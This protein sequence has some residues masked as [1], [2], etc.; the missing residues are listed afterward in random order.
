MRTQMKKET[1]REV[2]LQT[3]RE[4]VMKRKMNCTGKT[5]CANIE[6]EFLLVVKDDLYNSI[7]KE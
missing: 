3:L 4:K 5:H 2:S 6:N 1:K 7:T